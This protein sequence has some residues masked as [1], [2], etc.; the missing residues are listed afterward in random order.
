MR[1]TRNLHADTLA[2]GFDR[3][4]PIFGLTNRVAVGCS[5][6]DAKVINGIATHEHGCPNI[7][8]ECKGCNNTVTRRGS[9]CEDCQ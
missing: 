2:Q 7:V 6:C 4:S 1:H 5:Q 8:Y 9:Y 3:S